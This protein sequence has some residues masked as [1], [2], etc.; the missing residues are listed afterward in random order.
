MSFLLMVAIPLIHPVQLLNRESVRIALTLAAL[1]ELYVK[2]ADIDNT[3]L[4]APLS[5]KVWTMFGA[6]FGDDTINHALVV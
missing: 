2:M 6:E 5:D 4:M 1:H 3:Y